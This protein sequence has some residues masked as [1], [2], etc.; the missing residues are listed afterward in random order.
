[1]SAPGSPKCRNC[2]IW[3]MKSSPAQ[4][5]LRCALRT[6]LPTLAPA[7]WVF[8]HFVE[9]GAGG[10]GPRFCQWHGPSRLARRRAA[11]FKLLT[12]PLPIDAKTVGFPGFGAILG[13]FV[14]L[15]VG[16]EA[17]E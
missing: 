12:T 5:R 7:G 15:R 1:M 17:C 4:W 3:W 13:F 16:Q 8:G 2:I 14:G 9:R 6:P 10:R 11:S